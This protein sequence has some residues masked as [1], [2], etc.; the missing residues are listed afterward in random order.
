M[1]P[2]LGPV[3]QQNIAFQARPISVSFSISI[4]CVG[5][6]SSLQSCRKDYRSR[7]SRLKSLSDAA[8]AGQ[9][10]TRFTRA[11]STATVLALIQ[12]DGPRK[13]NVWQNDLGPATNGTGGAI[14]YE[15]ILH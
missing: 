11:T 9:V 15:R 14:A 6:G 4:S 5:I 1:T 8:A 3:L 7:R 13:G 10:E 12:T 2:S